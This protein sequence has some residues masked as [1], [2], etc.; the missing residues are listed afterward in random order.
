MSDP[1]PAAIEAQLVEILGAE[2][3]PV[4]SDKVIAR[5]IP[6]YLRHRDTCEEA[7]RFLA[8]WGGVDDLPTQKKRGQ[9]PKTAR[10]MLGVNVAFIL[11]QHGIELKLTSLAKNETDGSRGGGKLDRVLR[12]VFQAVGERVPVDLYDVIRDTILYENAE[13]GLRRAVYGNRPWVGGLFDAD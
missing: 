7:D 1:D 13:A 6:M 8:D 5:A 4:V 10:L 3:G 2:V 11:R 12:V 9:P